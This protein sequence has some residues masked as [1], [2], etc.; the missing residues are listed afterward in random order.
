MR[1]RRA[2]ERAILFFSCFYFLP[3]LLPSFLYFSLSSLFTLSS[4]PSFLF[5]T[6]LIPPSSLLSLQYSLLSPFLPI[7]SS[8]LLFSPSIHFDDGQD[9]ICCGCEDP[10]VCLCPSYHIMILSISRFCS[11]P[12]TSFFSYFIYLFFVCFLS[13]SLSTL[14]YHYSMS[15]YS[16]LHHTTPHNIPSH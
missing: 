13:F 16:I 4:S 8:L 2:C 11:L 7:L 15:Y 12:F 5:S 14:H 9:G 1:E 6:S 10:S 3:P